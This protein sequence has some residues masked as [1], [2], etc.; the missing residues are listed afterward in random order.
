MTR[1]LI[2]VLLLG[3]CTARPASAE[4]WRERAWI[5]ADGGMHTAASAFSDAFEIQQYTETETI[6]ADYR[7]K[8]GAVIDGSAGI[9]VW[10]RI[11]LG[12]AITRFS[13]RGPV[14]VEASI[15]HP[16]YD[17]RF[18]T[19][20]GSTSGARDELGTHLQFAYLAN[21]SSRLRLIASAGPS[22]LT[23]QQTLVTDVQFA[24]SYPYDSA[25]FTAATTRRATATA[26][27]FNAALD[28][29]WMV[30]RRIGAGGVAR[31]TRAR[32]R[33]HGDSG[34]TVNTDAGGFQ[35]AAGVRVLF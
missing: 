24:Q 2:A 32:V 27:G 30:G 7:P 6:N 28:A 17:N 4:R 11:G 14:L 26:P 10:R 16:L 22:L 1:R 8:A 19:V 3:I 15:P 35:A 21:V 18:R 25:S 5:T 29:F 13:H 20:Q 31:F 34:R 23:V 12:I 9:R 33:E